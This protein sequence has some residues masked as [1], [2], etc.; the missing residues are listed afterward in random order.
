VSIPDDFR[1]DSRRRWGDQ[2]QGWEERR[3]P[4]RTATMP[5]S[6]WMIEAID[7]QP[8]HIVL[9]LA[10]GTGDTGLLAAELIEPGGTLI[11]SDFSPE[12]L[13]TA[14]RRAEEL[15]V[16]NVRFK[17]IDAATSIDVEAASL[18]GVLCRWGYM[19]MADPGSA[20]RETRRVLKPGARVALAAW[21][22]PE[23]NPWSVLPNRELTERGAGEQ[24]DP[25]APHQF[26][27]AEEGVVA[28][29]LEA[30]GFGEHHVESLEFTM[31]YASAEDWWASQS[32]LSARFSAAL[33]SAGEADLAAA[34]AA[35]ERHAERFGSADGH[36]RIPARSWVAWAAA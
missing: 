29:Q 25:D 28:D 24:A 11:C 33:R 2:A 30:A 15:G 20:L 36:L 19:L 6:A 22:A 3:G 4:L 21:A 35:V 16:R 8:G 13:A 18:D 10:A 34:R 14:Q 12:M 31:D 26:S 1:A 7:P 23:D 9:E 5:V 17:Q 32:A 27:W